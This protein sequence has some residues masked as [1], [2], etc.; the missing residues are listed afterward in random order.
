MNASHHPDTILSDGTCVA[1]VGEGVVVVVG[2]A[3]CFAWLPSMQVCHWH[4]KAE[5]RS[6]CA[7]LNSVCVWLS[8]SGADETYSNVTCYEGRVMDG[9]GRGLDG[10]PQLGR[11]AWRS[12]SIRGSTR[13]FGWG[14]AMMWTACAR[15]T[16]GL[17]GV[18]VCPVQAVLPS[19]PPLLSSITGARA[20]ARNTFLLRRQLKCDG[21][22]HGVRSLLWLH[23]CQLICIYHM[24]D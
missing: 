6:R 13:G 23:S 12:P 1:R 4:F 24:F 22:T 20:T 17:S 15:A 11:L 18:R 7:R 19:P 5:S 3:W 16:G 2:G 9:P 10:T 21:I 14:C 8:L